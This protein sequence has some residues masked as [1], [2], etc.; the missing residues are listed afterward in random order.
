MLIGL[1]PFILQFFYLKDNLFQFFCKIKAAFFLFFKMI[2]FA[3]G[4]EDSNH[5][6]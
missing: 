4:L 5:G 2:F 6:N 3:S 1:L